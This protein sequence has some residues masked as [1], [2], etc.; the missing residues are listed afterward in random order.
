[1]MDAP[2]FIVFSEINATCNFIFLLLS[3]FFTH[4]IHIVSSTINK[5]YT[6]YMHI[7]LEA[8][9]KHNIFRI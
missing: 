2:E 4:K 6:S 8:R 7:F 1:M 3:H 5:Q 9:F